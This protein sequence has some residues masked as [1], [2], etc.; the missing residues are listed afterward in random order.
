MT[1]IRPYLLRAANEWISDNGLT[2]HIL[3]DATID[4]VV[5]PPEY[6]QEGKIALNICPTAV[7]DLTIDNDY[8]FFNAR[9][10]GIVTSIEAPLKA[11]LAVYAKENGR[12]IIFPEEEADIMDAQPEKISADYSRPHLKIVK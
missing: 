9:F 8:L 6:I 5:V 11:L 12:G 3:V 2:P 7:R 1:S 10:A 4:G